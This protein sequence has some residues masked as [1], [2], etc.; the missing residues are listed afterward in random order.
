MR[1][2]DILFCNLRTLCIVVVATA[3]SYNTV[4]NSAPPKRQQKNWDNLATEDE[5]AAGGPAASDGEINSFFQKLYADADDDTRRAM[6]K[7]Y[8]ESNG[9]S[10]STNW[11]DVS[12]G[13]VETKPPSGMEAKKVSANSFAVRPC[14]AVI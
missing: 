9:T 3:P 6:M 14:L 11:A 7:S 2:T 10:L 13:K 1:R 4:V 12:K 8:Q 5:V